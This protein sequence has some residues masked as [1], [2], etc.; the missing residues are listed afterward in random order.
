MPLIVG[1]FQT[2]G[3]TAWCSATTGLDELTTTGHSH[4]WEVSRGTVKEHDL[5]PRELGIP[6]A[7]IEQLQ[8][9]DAQHNARIVHACSPARVARSATS[10]C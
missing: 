2:R 3:A 9:G 1:V 5:D 6:R 10:S 8:G 7:T 4:I